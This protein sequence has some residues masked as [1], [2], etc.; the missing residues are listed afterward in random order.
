MSYIKDIIF[1]MDGTLIDSSDIIANSINHVRHKLGLRAL[2]KEDILKV[3]NDINTP[4]P[5][6][7]YESEEFLP[8]HISWFQDYYTLNHEEE[9][10]VYDGVKGMLQRLQE[11]KKSLSL[12]TNAYR[13]SAL[14]ILR[15][16]E[17]E[18]YFEIIVCGDDVKRSKPYP[19]MI[20]KIILHLDSNKDR[21]VLVG[22]S[23]KDRESAL[24]AGVKPILV[25]FGF[26]DKID[27][28]LTS[29]Y[30]LEKVL[31]GVK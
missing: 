7:F 27:N 12:A 25:N 3:V 17:M 11:E 5:L 1:D 28:A 2:I 8:E 9:V 30:D 14:Q 15:H 10:K 22:D 18:K 20:E 24:R 26:T 21:V 13:I 16:L 4:S 29:I 23:I 6:Y 31:L 19:D